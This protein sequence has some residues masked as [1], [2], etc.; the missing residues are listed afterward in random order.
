MSTLVREGQETLILMG[1][2]T[3]HSIARLLQ[4]SLTRIGVTGHIGSLGWGAQETLEAAKSAE[5]LVGMPSEILYLCRMDESLRPESVLLS[6]D[7]V[8]RCV[9]ESLRETWHCQVFTHFGMT[10]TGFGCAV[11]CASGEGHHLRHP[12]LILEIIDP[13][14]GNPLHPGERGEIV[15]TLLRKEAMPLIRYRTGD[16]ACMLTEPCSCGGIL[17]RLGRV[18]GHKENDI[19]LG[20]GQ[21]LS[22][23]Q[24]D[25]LIYAIPNVRAFKASLCCEGDRSTLLLKVEAEGV[26]DEEALTAQLPAEVNLQMRYTEVSPF[27][28]RG[29]RRIHANGEQCQV[30]IG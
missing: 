26:L 10:E 9:M 21:T 19:A 6:A 16:L 1:G 7:Y 24:L 29:K 2:D 17:P 30:P 25:E 4:T 5:C 22:I 14:T 20:D 13:D 11:Q 27:S 28:H 15:L 8:P 18:E 23:H 12:D 3:E